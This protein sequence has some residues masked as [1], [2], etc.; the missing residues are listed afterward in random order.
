MIE[1]TVDEIDS[2]HPERFLLID[3]GLINHTDV[4]NNLAWFTAVLGLETD[5]EPAMRLA[6]LLKASCRY[7]VGKHEER[8]L[9]TELLIQPLDQQA[10]FMIEH[11]L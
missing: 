6:M 5:A 10:V 1:R 2:D 3:V 9:M 11:C 7:R 8:T 4:D